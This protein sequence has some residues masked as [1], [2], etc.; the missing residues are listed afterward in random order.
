MCRVGCSSPQCLSSECAYRDG[1]CCSYYCKSLY[2]Q[3]SCLL[4]YR[5]GA[6]SSDNDLCMGPSERG[7][8]PCYP[9]PCNADWTACTNQEED[10]SL[11][12]KDSTHTGKRPDCPF[13]AIN[14]A[15]QNYIW[16]TLSVCK[17][18][19]IDEPTGKCNMVSRMFS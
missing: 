15:G 18:K 13:V 14:N 9:R 6:K 4:G 8:R 7:R 2:P 1:T 12:T 10:D 11:W 3:C 17:Q 16:Q 5:N 19:C